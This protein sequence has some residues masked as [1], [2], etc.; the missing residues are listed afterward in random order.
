M[1][2]FEFLLR[3]INELTLQLIKKSR[4]HYLLIQTFTISYFNN[5]R[6]LLLLILGVLSFVMLPPFPFFYFIFIQV[7]L[8]LES[9]SQPNIK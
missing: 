6:F 2:L 3:N 4:F 7:V 9:L 5:I 8:T 1:F